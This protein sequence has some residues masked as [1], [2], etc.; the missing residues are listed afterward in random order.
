MATVG[1]D[2]AA[3]LAVS[4]WTGAGEPGSR[5]AH[6]TDLDAPTLG[7]RV[8]DAAPGG[9]APRNGEAR[10]PRAIPG[11]GR[12]W[13]AP[14]S[15]GS[16]TIRPYPTPL[17]AGLDIWPDSPAASERT[18]QDHRDAALHAI[19]ASQPPIDS[20]FDGTAAPAFVFPNESGP[21]LRNM[22]SA[23]AA[24]AAA[25]VPAPQI[26]SGGSP[27]GMFGFLAVAL[28]LT[29]VTARLRRLWK[30]RFRRAGRRRYRRRFQ[31]A[32]CRNPAR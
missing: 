18:P 6:A 2:T 1:F 32:A 30:R 5:V 20:P 24:A 10:A 19:R 14:R 21:S 13:I 11:P 4:L 28:F 31:S 22:P 12:E 3:L 25:S 15:T 9:P 17:S 7:S 27:H 26:R 8:R 16:A 23:G 29:A